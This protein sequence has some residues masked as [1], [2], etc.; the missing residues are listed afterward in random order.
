MGGT[1]AIVPEQPVFLGHSWS[2]RRR[3]SSLEPKCDPRTSKFCHFHWKLWGWS[4]SGLL[5]LCF[6]L[7]K[8]VCP[9]DLSHCTED[10]GFGHYTYLMVGQFPQAGNTIQSHF[11]GNLSQ[12]RQK[13]L[14]EEGSQVLP[15]TPSLCRESTW[16]WCS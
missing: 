6:L 15:H 2:F 3:D 16:G 10:T 13:V 12:D 14:Q 1:R 8:W 4:L 11:Q 5:S 9:S 7:C